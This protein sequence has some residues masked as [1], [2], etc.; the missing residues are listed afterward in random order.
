ML[1]EHPIKL[2][3]YIWRQRR[4][5]IRARCI[6]GPYIVRS[7]RSPKRLQS[8]HAFLRPCTALSLNP[9]SR[10]FRQEA[11]VENTGWLGAR[12]R[13]RRARVQLC[14]IQLIAN[15][16][17]VCVLLPTNM[18]FDLAFVSETGPKDIPCISRKQS[19]ELWKQPT[20]INQRC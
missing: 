19:S 5:G 10:P 3:F 18:F 17:V 13:E 6:C 2:I 14:S 12:L 16:Y 11:A 7:F 20:D 9:F 15:K 4:T 1:R 8:N